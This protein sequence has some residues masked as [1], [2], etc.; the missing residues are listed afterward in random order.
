[1]SFSH[2]AKGVRMGVLLSL[3]AAMPALTR[4][5]DSDGFRPYLQLRSGALEISGVQDAWGAGLGVNFNR[6]LGFQLDFDAFER[7]ADWPGLD[8]IFENSIIS[9]TPEIRVRYP[10]ANGRWAPY[11]Y[12]GP[13]VTFF[14]FNDR[15]PPAFHR[16]VNGDSTQFSAVAGVGLEYYVADN[17]SFSVEAKYNWIN[18]DP[19]TVDG[20]RRKIDY[21][22]PLIMFGIRAYFRENHH[23]QLLQENEPEF[24]SRFWGGFRYGASILLDKH[25]NRDLRFEP[26]AAALGGEGNQAG[27]F[28][29]GYN[30]GAHWGFGIS[31]NYVEYDLASDRYGTIGEYANF[32]LIPEARYHWTLY[33]GKISP[34]VS[35]GVGICYSEFNDVKPA[36][37]N[38]Y[39]DAPK[40][41]YPAADLGVGAEYFFARNM[42]ASAEA[43]YITSW[44]HK[45][46]IN[47][48]DD[49]RASFSALNLYLGIRF[50]LTEHK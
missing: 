50:Y 48:I 4:A 12:A 32:M 39:I 17:I 13:G 42:S 40:G 35:A 18:S 37:E 36:S 3:L 44:G 31:A 28:L 8:Q 1:M 38:L 45:I 29:V 6:Y 26:V 24:P 46:P 11:A 30:L 15:K 41:V 47:H 25:L 5:E 7:K 22:S 27:T 14:S 10:L 2:R 23:R 21:S 19:V 20:E 16:M 43:H 34:F 49:G 9:L 33:D